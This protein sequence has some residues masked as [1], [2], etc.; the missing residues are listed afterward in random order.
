MTSRHG[1]LTA[2]DVT[3]YAIGSLT[4]KDGPLVVEVPAASDKASYFG[5]FVDA[6]QTPIADV[7][8]P[9]DDKGKGGK[10]LFLPPGYKRGCPQRIPGL[11]PENLQ[12]E[13]CFPTG[14]EERRH[15]GGSGSLQQDLKDLQVV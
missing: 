14:C 13:L 15:A 8:P 5:T 6:W 7:G 1:F 11:P 3:P 12:R 4:C 9:G 2:N 10:Y